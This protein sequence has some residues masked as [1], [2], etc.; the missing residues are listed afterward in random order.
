VDAVFIYLI[1]SRRTSRWPSVALG[2]RGVTGRYV[3][4]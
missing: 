1:Y 4:V 3:R 2:A